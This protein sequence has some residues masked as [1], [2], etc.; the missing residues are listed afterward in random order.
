MDR[1]TL[2][3]GLGIFLVIA[4]AAFVTFLFGRNDTFRGTSY[5]QPY[6]AASD[7]NLTRANGETFQLSD[8]RDKVTLLFFGYT[9][10]PDVCPTTMADL[11]RV[12]DQLSPANL[13]QVQVVFVTV[14][15]KRDTP[16]RVQEYVDHFNTS[17]VG[18]SG[19]E[20]ELAKV[21]NDYGIY[22]L[23]VPG[24]SAAGYSVDHTARITLI[25][26]NGKLRVSYG[27]DTPVEDLVH[28]VQ[29]LLKKG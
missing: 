2:S 10:C 21:W 12:L 7:F 28:D 4:V 13:K 25:D 15:P 16:E 19:S 3:V 6:P 29:L 24:A 22:R 14:D 27:F 5:D 17:F 26:K 18:L 1:K 23:E 9:S 20:E 8:H 11:K